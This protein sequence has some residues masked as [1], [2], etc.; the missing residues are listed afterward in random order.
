MAWFGGFAG[1]THA[2]LVRGANIGP[3][4]AAATDRAACRTQGD[5]VEVA[6]GP[7][8]AACCCTPTW[9]RSWTNASCRRW[10]GCTSNSR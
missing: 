8:P 1:F 4:E 3:D 10:P 2:D 7:A 6:I 5:L 9:S